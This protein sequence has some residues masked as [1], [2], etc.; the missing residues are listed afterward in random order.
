VNFLNVGPWEVM[1]ILVIAILVVGPKRMVEIA[2]TLGQI[3]A[4][5]R[6]L[7][8][9]FLTTIQSEI[10]AT[11]QETRATIESTVK[12]AQEQ[13]KGEIEGQGE[14]T[15]QDV[16]RLGDE[17]GI[18]TI[19]EELMA[20]ERETRRFLEDISKGP[21]ASGEGKNEDADAA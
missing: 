16:K 17:A 7:S 21:A 10:D 2:R 3:A 8:N 4:Q 13:V 6:S 11:E 18:S 14:E 15:R 20:T 5:V 12:G 1:V 19:K 9:E